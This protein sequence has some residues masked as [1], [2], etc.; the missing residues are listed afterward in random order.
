MLRHGPVA[1]KHGN[2]RSLLNA[3]SMAIGCTTGRQRHEVGRG[4]GRER[5]GST[6]IGEWSDGERKRNGDGRGGRVGQRKGDHGKGERKKYTVGGDR[7]CALPP[8]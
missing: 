8:S 6:D 5:G 7:T 3:G 1:S 2:R 4:G